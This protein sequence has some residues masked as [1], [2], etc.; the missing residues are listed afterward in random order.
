MKTK[1]GF[2]VCGGEESAN[3]GQKTVAR[4]HSSVDIAGRMEM[5]NGIA[6]AP[7]SFQIVVLQSISARSTAE[8]IILSCFTAVFHAFPF[9]FG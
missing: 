1:S 6:C 2:G 8:A 7:V 3:R 4:R 9:F 5:P